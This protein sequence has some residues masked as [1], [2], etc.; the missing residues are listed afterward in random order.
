MKLI[1]L[2]ITIMLTPILADSGWTTK[3]GTHV[4]ADTTLITVQLYPHHKAI[5]RK[6]PGIHYIADSAGD[7]KVQWLH[8]GDSIFTVNDSVELA[9][10]IAKAHR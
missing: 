5:I 9:S 6:T 7:L 2:F 4:V 10:L 8:G 3:N 1:L